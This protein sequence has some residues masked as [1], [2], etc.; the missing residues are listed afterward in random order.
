[1]K[2]KATLATRL[3]AK[4][5][6]IGAK[7]T[8]TGATF[9]NRK[10]SL[11]VRLAG[12]VQA[13][14]RQKL[15]LPAATC[16]G[17]SIANELKD[18]IKSGGSAGCVDQSQLSIATAAMFIGLITLLWLCQGCATQPSRSQTMTIRDTV[19]NVY[20]SRQP[21]P[22]IGPVADTNAP[23]YA[24][25]GGDTLCQAMMIETGGDEANSQDA[26]Q[27]QALTLPMGDT[28]ISALGELL[29][30]AITG[31]VKAATKKDDED[32]AP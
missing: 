11:G 22:V 29:G 32:A 21:M 20:V 17:K 12:S 26:S 6:K 4:A 8:A 7:K 18:R 15:G 9:V 31:G 1:M 27:R 28:A 19:I 14:M 16:G 13:K 24:V 5:M 2:T 30:S 10:T 23:P 3:R 25:A